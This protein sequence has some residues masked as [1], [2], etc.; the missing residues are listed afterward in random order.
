M[1]F[2]KKKKRV[3]KQYVKNAKEVKRHGSRL[4]TLLVVQCLRLRAL[5][6]GD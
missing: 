6:A 4:G 3:R 2:E 5:K 1:N